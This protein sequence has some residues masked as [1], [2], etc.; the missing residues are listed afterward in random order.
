MIWIALG[1]MSVAAMLPLGIAAGREPRAP[2]R[3]DAA[4]A[5]HRT[6][7]L[8]AE[9]DLV[10][11][12]RSERDSAGTVAD[13]QRRMLAS[14]DEREAELRDGSKA[15]LLVVLAAIPL[16]ALGLYLAN[17]S[18]YLPSVAG[19]A[20]VAEPTLSPG[21]ERD[22]LAALR[23]KA[24]SLPAR[25]M[26]ARAAY[27][28]LGRAEADQGD[29]SAAAAAWDTALEISFDPT[30]AAATAEALTEDSGRVGGHARTLF[31][32]ALAAAPAGA[33]WR[34]MVARRLSES[35]TGDGGQDG[36]A[37]AR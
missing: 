9:R 36:P 11:A 37:P 12:N 2:V 33:P 22:L 29:M 19:G 1:M 5:L 34:S 25:S 32:R 20:A 21:A 3:R 7:L 15:P 23:A 13:I 14:V 6:Q 24:A 30:L 31:E 10:A 17:G 26:D 27:I 35:G 16:L 18:P 28:A 4:L 8:E